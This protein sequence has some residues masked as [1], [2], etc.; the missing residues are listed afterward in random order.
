MSK[1]VIN[2]GDR[3]GSLVVESQVKIFGKSSERYWKCKCDCGGVVETS[4]TSLRSG[5]RKTCG[6]CR[7]NTVVGMRFGKLLV[8]DIVG[9]DKNRNLI[10]K[11]KCDCGN[12][13]DV[14]AHRLY[15][16]KKVSCNECV[17]FEMIGRRFGS[18]TVTKFVYTKDQKSWYECK[19]DCGNTTVVTGNHLR[20]GKTT[21]YTCGKCYEVLPD[22]YRDD[23]HKKCVQLSIIWNRI[24]NRC[25]NPKSDS[26]PWYGGSGI[27]LKISRYNFIKMFYKDPSF[28]PKLQIDRVD[29]KKNYEVGNLRWS[30]SE[31]NSK[32]KLSSYEVDYDSIAKKLMTML[33]FGKICSN[34]NYDPFDFIMVKVLKR[35]SVD[36]GGILWLFI[37]K[38]LK[39]KV[40]LYIDR[41]RNNY[42]QY[43]SEI[44]FDA[45]LSY[46]AS[47]ELI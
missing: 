40:D 44:I 21:H 46:Q 35:P 28:D 14:V 23:V 15:S 29:T 20:S 13:L 1:S 30:T 10:V 45:K 32:N 26:F 33:T 8:T 25:E 39:N 3:F 41:I 27:E 38:S 16:G 31:E 47:E 7:V 9:Y 36:K 2:I 22:S 43:D 11:C 17:R 37:H 5:N 24:H 6:H 34:N 12:E 4:T 19:C 42:I 18:L